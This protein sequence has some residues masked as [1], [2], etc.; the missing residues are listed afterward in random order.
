MSFYG[1]LKNKSIKKQWL[2]DLRSGNYDQTQGQLCEVGS[3]KCKAKYCC[4]GVL[5]RSIKKI[6]ALPVKHN[7]DGTLIYKNDFEDVR[8][9]ENLRAAIGMNDMTQEKLMEM[10]DEEHADFKTIADWIETNL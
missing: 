2:K 7:R 4:L 6:K 8:L 10:N 3:N 1:K 9:P 5:G